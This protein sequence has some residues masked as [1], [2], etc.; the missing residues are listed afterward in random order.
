MTEPASAE[1]PR[2]AVVR[3]VY[4]AINRGDIPAA[5]ADFA[6]DVAWIEPPDR[7]G[8]KTC[9]GPAAVMAHLSTA[10]A[11]WAEGGCTP[12]GFAVNG[13][14]VVVFLHIH[15]RL[16]GART[17]ITGDIADVFTFDAGRVVEFRS[18]EASPPALDFAG[19]A[20]DATPRPARPQ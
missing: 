1:D 14:R 3:A 2:F 10:R 12:T 17:W 4:A 20:P 11:P 9:H 8:G 13:A 6:P 15:V 7:P 19:L 18:F 5:V 16:T